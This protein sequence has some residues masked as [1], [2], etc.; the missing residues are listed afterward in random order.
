MNLFEF[1]G[2]RLGAALSAI[3]ASTS[4]SNSSQLSI[5]PIPLGGGALPNTKN[6]LT[7]STR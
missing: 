1:F 6:K 7:I 3:P 4:L 5:L 2:Y